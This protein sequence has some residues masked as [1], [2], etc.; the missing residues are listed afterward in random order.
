MPY[1]LAAPERDIEDLVVRHAQVFRDKQGINLLTGRCVQKID[2]NNQMVFGVSA[3]GQ[4]FEFPY[5]RLLIAT[6]SSAIKPDIPGFNLP[7]VF[8]LKNLD[9]GRKIKNYL[10]NNNIKKAIVIGMG[11]IALEMCETLVHLNIAVDMVKPNPA[12]LPWLEQSM[13]KVVK[14]SL[15]SKGVG[16]YAGHEVE[17]IQTSGDG[18][19]L[20]CRDLK[21]T[22]DMVL[23]GIGVTPNSQVAETA[24]L[25][26]SVNNSIAVGRNLKTSDKNIYSAGDCADAF[27]VVTSKKTWVPLALRANRTPTTS[28]RSCSFTLMRTQVFISFMKFGKGRPAES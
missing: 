1:N 16:L 7:G 23:A 27:H 12:F 5:D 25:E 15:E 8:V 18:L 21:L 9:D 17:R 6:G 10:R 22:A 26:L 4:N 2:P 14:E 24:N 20:I 28:S 13:A 3:D 19:E 11:Y